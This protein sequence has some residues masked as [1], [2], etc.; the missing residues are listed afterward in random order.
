MADDMRLLMV[1]M[2]SAFLGDSSNLYLDKKFGYP[3]HP[4]NDGPFLH[5]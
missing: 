5:L 3:E 4:T 1:S 2:I